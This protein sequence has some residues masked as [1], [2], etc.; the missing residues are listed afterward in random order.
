MAAIAAD[1]HEPVLEPAAPEVVLKL[2]LDIR[3]QGRTLHRQVRL[4]RR[5][6]VLNELIK[7]G[8]LRAVAFVDKRTNSRTGFTASRQRQ[9]DRILARSC[10]VSNYQARRLPARC[11]AEHDQNS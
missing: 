3:R 5:V 1:P 6:V 9:H 11:L 10:C 2:A 8:A 7:E 4:E